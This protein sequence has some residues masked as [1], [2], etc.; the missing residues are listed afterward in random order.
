MCSSRIYIY[1]FMYTHTYI[2]IQLNEQ[3]YVMINNDAF[4]DNKNSILN[5]HF[6]IMISLAFTHNNWS[7]FLK[8]R[9]KFLIF[10]SS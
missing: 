1:S 6:K 3:T 8:E 5:A 7:K 9:E 2:D 10:I 4:L